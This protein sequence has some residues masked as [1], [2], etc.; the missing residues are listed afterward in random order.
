MSYRF[1]TLAIHAGQPN[2][3]LTGAVVTPIYQTTTYAQSQLD[4]Q[5]DYCYSRASARRLAV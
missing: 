5:P 1:D 3:A 4:G 2:D